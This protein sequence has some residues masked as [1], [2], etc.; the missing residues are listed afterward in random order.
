MLA[1]K[2]I[3]LLPRERQQPE[4]ESS[5]AAQSHC[6]STSDST[7]TGPCSQ[8][9]IYTTGGGGSRGGGRAERALPRERQ[10]AQREREREREIEREREKVKERERERERNKKTDTQRRGAWRYK[11]SP[12]SAKTPLQGHSMQCGHYVCQ[13]LDPRRLFLGEQLL[14]APLLCGFAHPPKGPKIEKNQSRL[15]ISISLENFNLA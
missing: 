13:Q 8:A 11:T 1:Q 14:S 4:Q 12:F 6:P 9:G 10:G 3:G 5:A 2:R 15:K 7:V